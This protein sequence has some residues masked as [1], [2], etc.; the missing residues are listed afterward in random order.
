MSTTGTDLLKRLRGRLQGFMSKSGVYKAIFDADADQIN[1]REDATGDLQLQLSVDSA[2]WALSIFERE[3]GIPTDLNKP[4]SERRSVI[5][6]KMRGTGKVDAAMIK[7]VIDSWTDGGVDVEFVNSEIKVTFR[8]VV[9]IPSNMDDVR[10]AVEE[11]KPA[12]LAIVYAF[13]YNQYDQLRSYTHD[14]LSSRTHDQLRA[15][16]LP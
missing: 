8:S 4:L 1:K 14:Q 7:L 6:S 11:I 3:L 9:G 12:H 15:T 5:K 13:L 16:A 2:T 10:I